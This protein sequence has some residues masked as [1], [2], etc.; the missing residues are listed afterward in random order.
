MLLVLSLAPVLKQ[1]F[2]KFSFIELINGRSQINRDQKSNLLFLQRHDQSQKFDS[3]LLKI[4]K[5]HYKEIYIYYIEYIT[6]KKIDDWESIY[7]VNPSYLLVSHASGYI[8]EKNG[9]EYLVFDDSVNENK[10][11]L[12]KYTDV[13][14]GIKSKIKAINGG[15]ENDYGK[16]YMKIKFSSDDDLPLNKSLKFHA[17]AIF[18]RSVFEEDS[19]LYPQVFLDDVLYEL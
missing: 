19:K 4:D 3:S 14:D 13:W 15:K 12:K 7:S 1:H 2:I 16:D 11:L 8:E 9:N 6:I 18:I 10:E 17:M 5:K